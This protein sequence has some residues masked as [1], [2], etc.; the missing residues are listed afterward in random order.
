MQKAK[1]EIELPDLESPKGNVAII[2]DNIRALQPVYLAAMFDQMK[3][4]QVLDKLVELFQSGVLP[5]GGGRT[6]S[7][8]FKYWK[9]TQ[10]RISEGERRNFYARVLGLPGGDAGTNSNRDFNDLWIRFISSVADFVRQN[11]AGNPTTTPKSASQQLVRKAGL[12]LAANLSLHGYGWTHFLA[13]ELQKQIN[14]I[15]KL[16]SANE[17]KAAYGARDMWQVIDQVAN[18]ELGGSRNSSRYRTMASAGVTI[19]AWL[20]NNSR[21]LSRT[22]DAPILDAARISNPN[23]RQVVIKPKARP[24]DLDLVNACEQWLAVN[25][26]PDDSVD[27]FSQPR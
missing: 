5:V 7:D 21:K 26:T 3:A 25:G 4:F 2:A 18:L 14:T 24:T 11:P 22:T 23:R 8:F 19:I 12:Q 27:D 1:L 20:A 15:I 9:D 13:A 10:Q 17:I 16:L 6:G